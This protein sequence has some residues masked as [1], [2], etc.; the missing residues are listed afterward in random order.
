M[1]SDGE[2]RVH[3]NYSISP[4]LGM[5]WLVSEVNKMGIKL[6]LYGD[7]G[8]RTCM[9]Y[10]GHFEHEYEDAQTLAGGFIS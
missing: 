9:G 4:G 10:P 7:P 5:K 8:L 6:G 2:A 1:P 3:E